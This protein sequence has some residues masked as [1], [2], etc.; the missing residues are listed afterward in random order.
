MKTQ[1]ELTSGGAGSRGSNAFQTITT[2]DGRPARKIHNI[3]VTGGAGYIGSHACKALAGAGL[4]PVVLDNLVSGHRWA[5]KW[6]PLIEGDLNDRALLETILVEYEISAVMHF[7]A[8]AYVGE[9]M[10]DP[11]K[12]FHNNVTNTL[13]L[14]DAMVATGV[15]R[16]VFSSSC[17]TYGV[18]HQ[19]PISET[20][21]Q[22]PIN[23]YGESKLFVERMLHWYG[24]AHG[25]R[26]YALRY[27][28]AAGDDP[29]G[30]IGEDH[31]PETHLIPLVI[32][33]AL[34]QRS[35]VKIFGTDYNTPDGSAVRDY[36]HVCDLAEAHVL[37]VQ[38]L[39]AGSE[40]RFLNLGTG[41]G[42]SVRDIVTAVE[43]ICG[44]RV[45]AVEAPRRPGDPALLVAA[46]GQAAEILGWNPRYSDL[47]TIVS[48]ALAW[49]SKNGRPLVAM[50][51]TGIVVS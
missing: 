7:A 41:I 16:M 13:N 2:A 49:H 32:Q 30:Q 6:G 25:L 17:A 12:Y 26:A 27:F 46:P 51:R 44:L 28:N 23:P 14:L 42:L 37:A 48:T 29:G 24:M 11:G 45:N 36:I 33:T 50:S 5:V 39:L 22:R 38:Q 8:F 9:S 4:Q 18:P 31:D 15:E 34:N 20:H 21:P 47:N 3:L 43:Q 1:E 19:L 40:S 10:T 35:E